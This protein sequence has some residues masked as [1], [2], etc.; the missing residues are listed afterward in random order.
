MEVQQ[1][2]QQYSYR[3]AVHLLKRAQALDVV[4]GILMLCFSY[5]LFILT[6]LVIV[7]L[8]IQPAFRVYYW[9]KNNANFQESFICLTSYKYWS[10]E[11]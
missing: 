2:L 10:V 3:T 7:L 5:I 9:L 8:R 6:F 4:L 1:A 11:E